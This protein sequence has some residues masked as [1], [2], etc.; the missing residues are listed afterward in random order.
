MDHFHQIS[1]VGKPKEPMLEGWT[2][3][4]FLAGVTSKIKLGTLVAGII[5]RYPS[6]LA[7]IAATLD[8][9]SNGRLFMR[10]GAAWNQEESA[11]YGIP[12]PSTSDRFVMLEEAVQLIRKMWNKEEEDVTFNGRFYKLS[13]AHCN[14]KP[15]QE[16]M[17]PI[18][19]GGSGERKILKIVA[20]YADVCNLFGSSETIRRKLTILS[21][22]CKTVNRDYNTI[23][24][25]KLAY[26]IIA[27]EQKEVEKRVN[28]QFAGVAE[29][30]RR[31]FAIYGTPEQVLN[32][33]ELF[34]DVGIDYL[35]VNFEP[36]RELESVN[37]FANKVIKKCK[38][39][40]IADGR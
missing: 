25:T 29:E 36:L 9:L 2:T 3:I 20:K 38:V 28:E 16:P 15:I 40:L 31:E 6:I 14:P 30:V 23:L 26:I 5:Y 11:A 17:P 32:Q 27:D 37:T 13:N 4:S 34:R 22:H 24:K 33:I 10:I 21:A 1:V 19:I 8:V 18:M 7:K 12:F 39:N 35:I